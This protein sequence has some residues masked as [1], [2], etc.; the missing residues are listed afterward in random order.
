MIDCV[1]SITDSYNAVVGLIIAILTMVFGEH[2]VLF[3][4]FLLFNMADWFTGWYRSRSNGRESSVKG[5]QGIL[6][7]IF[8]WI[9]ISISFLISVVFVEVGEVIGVNLQITT[10]FG[11]FVLASLI[12]N[13]V[14]S[15][16]ENLLGIGVNVPYILIKG[17]EITDKT[18]D[19]QLRL[20]FDNDETEENYKMSLTIPEEELKG[21]KKIVLRVNDKDPED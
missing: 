5:L 7:K 20:L 21:K 6:K 9:L 12:V 19:G 2:W 4:A 18:I 13:E 17:L 11:W 16:I 15:I 10:V 14:R 3:A 1:N 8:Y